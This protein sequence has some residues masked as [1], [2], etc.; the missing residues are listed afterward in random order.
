MK[1]NYDFVNYLFKLLKQNT[2]YMWDGFGSNV[3]SDLIKEKS[4]KYPDHYDKDKIDYLK[5]L[6]NKNYFS[7]DCS[8]LIKSFWM[9]DYG[10][11]ISEF[12][13]IYDKD[14]YEITIGLASEKGSIDTLPEIPGILLYMKGHC[15]VYIGNGK[16]IECTSNEVI[17]KKKYGGVCISNLEDRNWTDWTKNKWLIYETKN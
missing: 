7:Y 11:K 2:V 3:T 15:G 14:S 10:T 9:T 4:L 13:P 12:N 16:V 1:T 6:V 8:G 5:S 17:S